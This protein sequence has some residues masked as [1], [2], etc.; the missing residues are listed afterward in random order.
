MASAPKFRGKLPVFADS[1]D[2]EESISTTK[3]L[4]AYF[5]QQKVADERRRG[6]RPQFKQNVLRDPFTGRKMDFD[7]DFV[8]P[9]TDRELVF[10][11][12]ARQRAE[13][14]AARKAKEMGSGSRHVREKR[15]LKPLVDENKVVEE[16]PDMLLRKNRPLMQQRIDSRS[17]SATLEPSAR[18][19][20][21]RQTP[22]PQPQRPSRA[23]TP[24]SEVSDDDG[25][26]DSLFVRQP[27]EKRPPRTKRMPTPDS[28]ASSRA[29][30]PQA[31]PS[32]P[33]VGEQPSGPRQNI[34]VVPNKKPSPSNTLFGRPKRTNSIL[35]HL[36][37]GGASSPLTPP[38]SPQMKPRALPRALPQA[39][40]ERPK[41]VPA[42]GPRRPNI[43][44]PKKPAV[45]GVGKETG[46][47]GGAAD[48]TGK[49]AMA[50]K[51]DRLMKTAPK[52]VK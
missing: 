2:E 45:G 20:A 28:T 31:L 10:S 17:P 14:A 13:Q 49:T 34:T 24:P 29:S 43:F 8:N 26:D 30:T 4:D 50:K 19:A 18:P 44:I 38:V 7:A 11:A 51:G 37:K 42:V 36:Q 15:V 21:A 52:F 6:K 12:V 41:G 5:E 39:P 32:R 16:T 25:D 33:K 3:D 47:M 40:P 1:D 46:R 48:K 9:E 22:Q 35:P 23:P 27:G